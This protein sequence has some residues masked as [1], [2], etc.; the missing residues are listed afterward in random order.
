MSPPSE[1][2]VMWLPIFGA[3]VVVCTYVGLAQDERIEAGP[4]G[5]AAL[6]FE[7]GAVG[8][9]LYWAIARYAGL[10]QQMVAHHFAGGR[11]AGMPLILE[12][13]GWMAVMWVYVIWRAGRSA[14]V[15]EWMTGDVAGEVCIPSAVGLC[16]V[17][18]L[19]ILLPFFVPGL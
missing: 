15:P 16:I 1:L 11:G 17:Q 5:K 4:S 14:H 18:A 7:F 10:S 19:R 8:G 3:I 6:A 9:V 12:L 2:G 13:A